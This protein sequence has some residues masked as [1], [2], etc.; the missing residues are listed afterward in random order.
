MRVRALIIP[1]LVVAMLAGCTP[2]TPA[3]SASPSTSPSPGSSAQTPST[4]PT[5]A[6]TQAAVALPGSCDAL[7]PLAV[8]QRE[9]S[10]RFETIVIDA[11]YGDPVAQDFMAR[12]GITCLWG[13]PQS[14]AG[15][16]M[17]AAERA[18]S[19]DAAQVAQWTAAGF[20]QCSEFDACY[21]ELASSEEGDFYTLHALVGGFELRAFSSAGG[22]DAL[23]GV[24]IAAATSMGY[25]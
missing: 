20:T 12:G 19:T 13:I 18:T 23:M 4:A 16:T 9:F 8:V 17:Y 10:P 25:N 5:A 22:P 14:G 15:Y 24:A 21:Y 3:P 6:P 1:A 7:V 11:S 2:Q